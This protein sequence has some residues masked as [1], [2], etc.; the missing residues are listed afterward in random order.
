MVSPSDGPLPHRPTPSYFLGVM[1][2]V[3]SKLLPREHDQHSHPSCSWWSKIWSPHTSPHPVFQMFWNI[4][5]TSIMVRV[6]YIHLHN[7]LPWISNESVATIPRREH[8]SRRPLLETSRVA[9]CR[10]AANEGHPLKWLG[11][12]VVWSNTFSPRW[13]AGYSEKMVDWSI[14]SNPNSSVMGMA[15]STI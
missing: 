1:S 9:H 14:W 4:M 8:Q 7:M 2:V 3:E 12:A 10:R 5:F 13:G 6:L 15:Q 11:L